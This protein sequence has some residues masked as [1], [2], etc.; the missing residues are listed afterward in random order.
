MELKDILTV[1]IA[2]VIVLV[3][4]HLAVFYVVKTLY[5]PAPVVAAAPVYMP[6][7]P[8]FTPPVEQ[9]QSVNVPTYISPVPAEAPRKEE[10]RAGPPPPEATSIHGNSGVDTPQS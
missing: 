7:P 1:A 5:P 4:A 3:V 8:V 9:M 6:P 2:S 10:P